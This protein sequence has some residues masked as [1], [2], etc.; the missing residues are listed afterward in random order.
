MEPA[1]LQH[2]HSV[3]P[4][5][6]PPPIY[7]TQLSVLMADATHLP[8]GCRPTTVT[9]TWLNRL[10]ADAKTSASALLELGMATVVLWAPPEKD[11]LMRLQAG[12]QRF[13]TTA[14]NPHQLCLVV[15]LHYESYPTHKSAQDVLDFTRS[16][17]ISGSPTEPPSPSGRTR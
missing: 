13:V 9:R 5:G 16:W 14:D 15:L 10:T 6:S 7:L 17:K 12:Y 3:L 8:S 4:G 1:F 2:L 11:A